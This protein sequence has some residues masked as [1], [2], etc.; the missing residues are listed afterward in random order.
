MERPTFLI[1][2]RVY[3]SAG[4]LPYT[5][6]SVGT[7]YFLLQR[8][9]NEDRKW[10]YEDFGGRSKKEDT[11][12][13]D[14]AFRECH[15]ETNNLEPFTP[16]FLDRQLKDKRSVI[17]RINECKYM[18]YF[19]YVPPELKEDLDLDKFGIKN[20]DEQFRVLEWISYKSLMEIDDGEFQPRF[21]PSEFKYN[22][23]LV[24]AHPSINA[25]SQ[26]F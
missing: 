4:V 26:Y 15:E 6:D 23:P 13:K 16:D 9:T 3:V 2:N 18:M 12:I 1:K 8:L 19:I 14:V 5:I 25:R 17:Y 20:D 21:M 11:C 7:Y 24:L 22:L 10:T